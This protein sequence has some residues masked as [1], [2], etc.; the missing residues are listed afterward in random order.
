[1]YILPESD[2]FFAYPNSK[3]SIFEKFL[4]SSGNNMFTWFKIKQHKRFWW[5]ILFPF[6]PFSLLLQIIP[7]SVFS[8]YFQK[9][10]IQIQIIIHTHTNLYKLSY[11]LLYIFPFSLSSIPW[12]ALLIQKWILHSFSQ[13]YNIPVCGYYVFI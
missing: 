2:H 12:A 5:N 1:M 8:V 9:F 13:L 4:L 6:L 10:L 3:W 7:L 11:K